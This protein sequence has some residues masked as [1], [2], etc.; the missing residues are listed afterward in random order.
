M[1][2]KGF[3]AFM[4][5]YRRCHSNRRNQWLHFA[6]ANLFVGLSATALIAAAYWLLPI[7]VFAG[8]LL[9]HIGHT[10]CEGNRSLRASHPIYCVL[11]A[12]LLYLGMWGELGGWALSKERL[13]KFRKS[14]A[15]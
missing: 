15:A 5:Y 4:V 12:A 3:A 8:Y 2:E 10:R 13:G 9:P 14:V 6:G 11:G 1:K 7:A